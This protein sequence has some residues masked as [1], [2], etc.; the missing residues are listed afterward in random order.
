MVGEGE[1]VS[2]VDVWQVER[3]MKCR[4]ARKAT[5]VGSAGLQGLVDLLP[6]RYFQAR[7]CTLCDEGS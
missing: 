6:A 1:E 7:I 5:H 4:A 3:S 2:I